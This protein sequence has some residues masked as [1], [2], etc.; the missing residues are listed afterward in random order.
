MRSEERQSNSHSEKHLSSKILIIDDEPCILK[1]MDLV[2]SAA[3]H[4][5]ETASS[6]EIGLQSFEKS[7]EFEVVIT[8]YKLPGMNGLELEQ[9]VLALKPDVKV[10]LISGFGGIEMALD[11]MNRGAAD[12][13]RKP[14]SPEALRS[15]VKNAVESAG[16][17]SPI[18][19]VSREFSHTNINGF[20][21][22]LVETRHDETYGDF[23]YTF[24]LQRGKED[25]RRMK[26]QLPA[27][28][29]ELIKAHIDS[30]TV[31]CGNRFYEA[32]C[33]EKLANVLANEGIPSNTTLVI[34]RL[35]D[36]EEDWL[37]KMMTVALA[38]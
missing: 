14:F 31:P 20:S 7:G 34:D 30:D 28:S 22:E 8:D 11:A 2:L 25:P 24:E 37:D 35:G 29:Q 38:D 26:I 19:T 32:F 1:M 13:L 27:Y 21:F 4:E 15:A 9:A 6:A 23:E 12:F 10:I 18:C 3:G 33:E 5:V 36:F 17:S 16:V